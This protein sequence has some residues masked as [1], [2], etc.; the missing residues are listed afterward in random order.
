MNFDKLLE[1]TKEEQRINE[2]LFEELIEENWGSLFILSESSIKNYSELLNNDLEFIHKHNSLHGI[3]TVII[4]VIGYS[5]QFLYDNY[6]F[7]KNVTYVLNKLYDTYKNKNYDYKNS[8]EKLLDEYGVQS[9]RVRLTDKVLRIN[10]FKDNETYKVKT[11]SIID[12]VMDL[13]N[14]SLIYL[15]WYKKQEGNCYNGS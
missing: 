9:L 5:I 2:Q 6:Y 14:Y 11:E 7:D 8:A 15:I 10:A 12:T 13:I 4:N 1:Y 3:A